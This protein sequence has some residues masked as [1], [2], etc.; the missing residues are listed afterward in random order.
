MYICM[1]VYELLS[2]LYRV[3]CSAP[4]RI[5]GA[6]IVAAVTSVATV[7]VTAKSAVAIASSAVIW[8]VIGWHIVANAYAVRRREVVVQAL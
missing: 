5:N 6:T 8:T 2:R 1:Y 4:D 3:L 7:A